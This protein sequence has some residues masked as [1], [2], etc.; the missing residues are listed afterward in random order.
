M[1]LQVLPADAAD[2]PRAAAI[3]RDAYA[4]NPFGRF[5]FPGPPPADAV[6][7]RSTE[8]VEQRD[9]DPTT[10]WFKVVDTD[11]DPA[12]DE[13]TVAFARFHVYDAPREPGPAPARRMGEWCNAEA[14][15]AVFGGISRMHEKVVGGRRCICE[16]I[17][18][19]SAVCS[20][21]YYHI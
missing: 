7:R 10:R 18:Y 3:E 20:S 1:P 16:S 6:A 4:P 19:R 17:S 13:A 15:E 21:R 8:L 14:C 5:L 12:G 2:A 9:A 11:A